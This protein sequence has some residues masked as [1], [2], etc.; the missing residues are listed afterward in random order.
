MTHAGDNRVVAKTLSWFVVFG[1]CLAGLLGPLQ[2]AAA[3]GQSAEVDDVL[4]LVDITGSMKGRGDG[5]G[6]IWDEVLVHIIGLVDVLPAESQVA[7]VPFDSG[8]RFD[9][10]YL[11]LPLGSTEIE[12]VTLE[13]P[14]IREQ[15]K[16]H[17]RALPVDGQNTWI[18]ESLEAAL[19]LMKGWQAA[20]PARVHRQL[21]FLYTDGQDNGPHRDLGIAG[22]VRLFEAARTDMPYLYAVYGDIRYH[23]PPQ[24]RRALEQA[25]IVVTAG[26]PKRPVVVLTHD[27]DFGDLSQSP[28]GV[29]REITFSSTSPTVWGTEVRLRIEGDGPVTLVPETIRLTER[30]RILLKPAPGG[31]TPGFHT[32]RLVLVAVEEGIVIEPPTINLTFHWATPTP[33]DTS[34]ATA[35]VTRP[36]TPTSSATA[37]ATLTA[38]PTPTIT[39]TSSPTPSPTVK[40]TVTVTPT[41]TRTPLPAL[42]LELPEPVLN[43]G[44]VDNPDDGVSISLSVSSTSSQA[45]PLTISQVRFPT[46]SE[47]TVTL[48]PVLI[49]PQATVSVTLTLNGID[50]LSPGTYDGEVVF[51]SRPGVEIRPE[52]R[53][54]LRF[55]IMGLWERRWRQLLLGVAL[56]LAIGGL[57]VGGAWAWWRA[58]PAPHGF[59]HTLEAPAGATRRTYNLR[60]VRKLRGKNQ[61]TVGRSAR[62]DLRLDDP[63]VEPLHARIVAEMGAEFQGVGPRRRRVRQPRH[64]LQNLSQGTCSVDGSAVARGARVHLFDGCQVQIGGYRFRYRNPGARR[65]QRGPA[66]GGLL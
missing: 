4:I 53:V 25:G 66:G 52:P 3:Q 62:C 59:L 5:I 1:L 23:L 48:E 33:T 21:L 43:F 46:S 16:A 39:P 41:P 26:I 13:Y 6:D 22:I 19:A 55:H 28:Q 35:T 17:L 12:P 15:I 58:I 45:E 63:S 11:P 56:V 30:V 61:V 38:T 42:V 2:V 57:S 31:M 9:Q 10:T 49:P 37:T 60:A 29:S 7:I 40:P 14:R 54:P 27:L 50:S 34:T 65:G 64:F 8:I 24:D 51:T 18:Y 36:A 44:N 20:D 47:V 32:A